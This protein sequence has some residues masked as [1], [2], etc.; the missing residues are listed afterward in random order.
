MRS[1]EGIGYFDRYGRTGLSG[2]P[3]GVSCPLST[4]EQRLR[5]TDRA[6]PAVIYGDRST[7][8]DGSAVKAGLEM[9]IA[10]IWANTETT[11]SC[12]VWKVGNTRTTTKDEFF[13]TGVGVTNV[14]GSGSFGNFN[15][16]N[17]ATFTPSFRV[18]SINCFFTV[19]SDHVA[20]FTT[21]T[22]NRLRSVYLEDE[23]Y[24]FSQTGSDVALTDH[25]GEANVQVSSITAAW[26]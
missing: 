12:D 15:G 3:A 22:Q 24:T 17:L 13:E 4:V 23:A 14:E 19:W 7:V 26:Q 20:S 5:F 25:P 8:P 10:N 18:A 2:G 1:C 11:R 16:Q 6:K 21:K 9:F